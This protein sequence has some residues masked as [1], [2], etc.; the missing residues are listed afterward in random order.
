MREHADGA[1]AAGGDV[2]AHR[3]EQAAVAAPIVVDGAGHLAAAEKVLAAGPHRRAAKHQTTAA[4][5]GLSQ[6]AVTIVS[7]CRDRP[8]ALRRHIHQTAEAGSDA[9]SP[10]HRQ[11]D[12]V[13]GLFA[14]RGSAAAFEIGCDGLFD[15]AAAGDRLR[16]DAARVMPQGLNGAGAGHIDLR[17]GVVDLA[18]GRRRHAI[19][20]NRQQQLAEGAIAGAGVAAIFAVRGDGGRRHSVYTTAACNGLR[21]D[22]L[23]EHARSRDAAG[24]DDDRLSAISAAG[25]GFGVPRATQCDRAGIAVAKGC[26]GGSSLAAATADGLGDEAI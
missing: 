3:D 2:I 1:F 10:S 9:L 20:A 5:D 15:A 13:L 7:R 17:R 21:D 19:G 18:L 12:V 22:A 11:I 23:R 8:A 4:G 16:H 14:A 26:A 25:W 6:D 24:V